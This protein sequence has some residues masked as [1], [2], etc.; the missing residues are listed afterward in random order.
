MSAIRIL[1]PLNDIHYRMLGSSSKRSVNT[2]SPL[3]TSASLSSPS[4]L[5][6]CNKYHNDSSANPLNRIKRDLFGSTDS[7]ET[8]RYIL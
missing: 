5:G 1:N 7:K 6:L 8:E 2:F 4:R 3:A